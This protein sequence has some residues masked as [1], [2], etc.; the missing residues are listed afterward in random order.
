ML[1]WP[2][3]G[4]APLPELKRRWPAVRVDC[5]YDRVWT[6]RWEDDMAVRR[7]VRRARL[8]TGGGY[9]VERPVR[10]RSG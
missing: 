8:V 5:G 7:D 2:T 10:A 6:R 9:F 4:S 3:R 1:E